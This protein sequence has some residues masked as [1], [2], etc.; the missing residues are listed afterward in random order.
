MSTR[1]LTRIARL[2]EEIAG[3]HE[4]IT[5]KLALRRQLLEEL[6]HAGEERRIDI[7]DQVMA[8]SQAANLV[9][10]GRV[11]TAAQV[12]EIR[13]AYKDGESQGSLARRFGLAQPS[14]HK[15]VHRQSYKD[16]A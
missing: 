16:V 13:Q 7:T 11:L 12:R 6:V 14:V 1:T 3:L 9:T 5:T 10:T 2:D 15:I 8:M 4:K